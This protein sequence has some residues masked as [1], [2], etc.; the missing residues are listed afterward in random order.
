MEEKKFIVTVGGD[1]VDITDVAQLTLGD[2][3]ALKAA[4]YEADLSKMREW[5]V[6]SDSQFTLYV[7]RKF[8]PQTTLG[9]VDAIPLKLAQAIALHTMRASDKVDIPFSKHS[10]SSAPSTDGV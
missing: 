8:R 2:K 4:P 9:E 5:P 6:E 1:Q 10:T 3:K 7:L